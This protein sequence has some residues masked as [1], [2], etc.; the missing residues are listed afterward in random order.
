[1]EITESWL[2]L[3]VNRYDDGNYEV[4]DSLSDRRFETDNWSAMRQWLRDFIDEITLEVEASRDKEEAE[5]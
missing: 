5:D 1:M 3:K 2:D 4:Y